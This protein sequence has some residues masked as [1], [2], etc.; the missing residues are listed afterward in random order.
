MTHAGPGRGQPVRF[1]RDRDAQRA[2]ISAEASMIGAK[3]RVKSR[4][5]RLYALALPALIWRHRLRE[6]NGPERYQ[7]ARRPVLQVPGTLYFPHT[8]RHLIGASVHR[9]WSPLRT[10]VQD[11]PL[12]F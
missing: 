10:S 3:S 11:R 7:T 12:P 4:A 2:G 8:L 5:S 9:A 6:K 1:A